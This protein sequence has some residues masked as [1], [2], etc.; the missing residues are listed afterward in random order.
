MQRHIEHHNAI[1][2]ASSA[3][4]NSNY[5]ANRASNMNPNHTRLFSHRDNYNRSINNNYNGSRNR[6]NNSNSSN[7]SRSTSN[8]RGGRLAREGIVPIKTTSSDRLRMINTQAESK[9]RSSHRSSQDKKSITSTSSTT[10]GSTGS[11]DNVEKEGDVSSQIS[12][13]KNRLNRALSSLQ[14]SQK[15]DSACINAIKGDAITHE[16]GVKFTNI[17]ALSSAKRLL[18]EALIIPMLAPELFTGI[19]QPWKGVLLFGP[20]GTGKTMLAKAVSDVSDA[21][22]F[23]CSASTLI[24]KWRGDSEK[25][26]SCLFDAARACKI[27]TIFFDEIDAL[28]SSRAANEHE[29]TRR[30]KTELFQHMDGIDSCSDNNND[31]D[32]NNDNAHEGYAASIVMVLATTNRPWDLDDAMIRRLEKRIFIPLPD[33]EARTE[34]LNLNLKDVDCA[35]DVKSFIP[36]LVEQTQGYSGADIKLLMREAAMAPT[37]RLLSS[38]MLTSTTASTIATS[39]VLIAED[40]EEMQ[41][42]D[43]KIDIENTNAVVESCS[44]TGDVMD[45]G[46]S[47]NKDPNTLIKTARDK[48]GGK[49]KSPPMEIQDIKDALLRSKPSISKD[50]NMNVFAKWNEEFGSS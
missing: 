33:D 27:A 4:S 32:N 36:T 45:K 15:H 46:S 43:G 29:A 22:F 25:I 20:P 3:S 47:I 49:L 38:L 21:V 18:H 19:R 31:D 44:K 35:E 7:N 37:R 42:D 14:S 10:S 8:N 50:S 48:A 11:I 24:S 5:G 34:L 23:N 39:T 9:S 13:R 26:L 30:L 41:E 6:C 12:N 16:L 28:A 40:K 17:A 1:V 2:R